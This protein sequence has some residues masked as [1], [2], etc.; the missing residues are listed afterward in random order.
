MDWTLRRF[1]GLIRTVAEAIGSWAACGSRGVAW[2]K[3]VLGLL[4]SPSDVLVLMIITAVVIL[5]AKRKR[6]PK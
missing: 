2:S 4:F 1:Y 5:M 3:D 6:R